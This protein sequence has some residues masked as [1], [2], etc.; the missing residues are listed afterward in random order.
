MLGSR[1]V[2]DQ[3]AAVVREIYDENESKMAGFICHLLV[4]CKHGCT[5]VPG[6]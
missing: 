2:R 4:G 1:L 6:R 5:V 3:N